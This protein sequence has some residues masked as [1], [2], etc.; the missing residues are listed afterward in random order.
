MVL[1]RALVMLACLVVVPLAAI[2]GSAFPE[3]VRSVLVD[4]VLGYATG[5]PSSSDP[6]PT[7]SETDVSRAPAYGAANV[8]GGSASLESAAP[9]PTASPA[10]GGSAQ[11]SRDL[12]AGGA[13]RTGPSAGAVPA[14][15]SV[16]AQPPAWNSQEAQR[17]QDVRPYAMPTQSP[18][19]TPNYAGT[20]S[21]A[22][23][24]PQAPGEAH[25][26]DAAT[27]PFRSMERQL[28]QQGATYYLL[29]T[30]GTEGELYR[31]HC[32]MAVAGNANYTRH[33]EATDRDAL[34]AMRHVLEQVDAWRSGRLD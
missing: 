3:V 23:G 14:S 9:W 18:A 2:F 24:S 25:S 21:I 1:F 30:W 13:L 32:K 5:K 19:G 28:R 4:R 22:A 31:F 8:Q 6:G 34:S 33:F 20:S 12:Q 7:A 15:F 17:A 26:A 11:P 27:D 16:P 10:P 29:E